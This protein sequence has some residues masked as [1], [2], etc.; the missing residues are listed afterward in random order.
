MGLT[1]K[2]AKL[3]NIRSTTRHVCCAALAPM[4]PG[5][6]QRHACRAWQGQK[7]ICFWGR[8]RARLATQVLFQPARPTIVHFALAADTARRARR[9]AFRAKLEHLP[10]PRGVKRAQG[11]VL[12]PTL[13]CLI[14]RRAQIANWARPKSALAKITACCVKQGLF[15]MKWG[16]QAVPSALQDEPQTRRGPSSVLCV[17]A[18]IIKARRAKGYVF[19]VRQ[20]RLLP[21]MKVSFVL[22]A[23]KA[24]IQRRGLVPATRL[25]TR[26]S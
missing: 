17:C 20:D 3:E 11:A 25:R 10:A 7:R 13:L 6:R 18:G 8:P 2:I 24:L 19:P 5:L 16:Q 1:V 23:P 21:T 4:L 15:Q 14:P 22:S 9:S 12:E 26:I